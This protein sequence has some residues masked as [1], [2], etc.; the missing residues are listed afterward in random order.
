[1]DRSSILY[2]S[3]PNMKFRIGGVGTPHALHSELLWRNVIDRPKSSG[4]RQSKSKSSV[5]SQSKIF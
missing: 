4:V 1:M 2:N 3:V 5:V